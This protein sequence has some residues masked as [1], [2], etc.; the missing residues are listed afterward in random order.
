MALALCLGGALATCAAPPPEPTERAVPTR[1]STLSAR[2]IDG[3]AVDFAQALDS[4]RT[5]VLVFWQTWCASCLAEAPQLAAAAR[6]HP[7]ELVFVGIVPGPDGTV[8]EAELRRLVQRFD[9]PYP[10]VRDRELVWSKAFRITGTPTLVALRA[11]GSAGW[12]DHRP[13]ADWLALHRKLRG[14]R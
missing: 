2:A 9:L 14:A 6:E 5:V 11:D 13:P 8:D 3:S 1:V 7:D 10:Q 12:R 4:G